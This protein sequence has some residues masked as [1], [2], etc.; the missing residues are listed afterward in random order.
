MQKLE[1]KP[2]PI[3]S[4]IIQR[5]RH[6]QFMTVL[7]IIAS[8]L[9]KMATEIRNLQRTEILEVEEPFRKDRKAPACPTRGIP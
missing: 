2:C 9:E 3:S 8:S 1:L 4:Q 7:A 5:D 6:A